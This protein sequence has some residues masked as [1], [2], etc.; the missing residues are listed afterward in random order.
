MIRIPP[1][2]ASWFATGVHILRYSRAARDLLVIVT[3]AGMAF[4]TSALFDINERLMA[5]LLATDRGW[6][7]E[8]PMVFFGATI[9]CFWYALRR[10]HEYKAELRRRFA[11]E[12]KLRVAAEEAETASRA[13]SEF[14]ANMSHE[15]RTPLNGILGFSE[16]LAAGHFGPL[17]ARQREYICDIN[18]SGHHLLKI[19]S[20]ILDMAKLDAGR[21]TLSED[22]V[23][24][25]EAIE[26]CIRLVRHRADTAKIGLV[27]EPLANVPKLRADDLRVRQIVINLLSNAIKFTPQ[28]GQVRVQAAHRDDGLAVTIADTGIGMSQE[29]IA[30]ALQPFGQVENLL[31]RKY[32]GTGL[33][34]PIVNSLIT[35]HGGRLMIESTPGSGTAATVVFPTSRIVSNPGA[36]ET[37]VAA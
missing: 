11:L 6:L 19:I 1:W 37:V 27:F 2:I 12:Q 30:I 33:G 4:I 3:A 15:L 20:D 31:T 18:A 35:L 10:W 23:D 9:G 25:N 32:E 7:T 17:T 36:A 13:K 34:L 21:M 16:A 5:W 8:L 14:L 24:V 29:E 22:I 26:S 28:D